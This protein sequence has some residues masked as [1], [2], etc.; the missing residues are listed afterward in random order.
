MAQCAQHRDKFICS[1]TV[2]EKHEIISS[3]KKYQNAATNV[4]FLTQN[5]LL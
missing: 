3:R 5:S 1:D 2:I 4:K